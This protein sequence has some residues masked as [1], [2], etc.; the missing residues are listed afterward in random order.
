MRPVFSI[1][2]L[3]LIGHILFASVTVG[4][5]VSYAFWIALAELEPRHLAFTI[6]AVRHSDRLVAIPAYLLTFVT[7][8]WLV[9]ESGVPL[10]RLW[11]VVSLVVY[12][13][14]LVVG[15][16]VFGPTVR[17][18]LVAL[19]RGGV[20]DAEY[21]RLRGQAQLLSLGTIAALAMI[22]ALMVVKPY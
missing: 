16:A 14:V 11:I 13:A 9:Y 6:R 15:F 2:I 5:T 7:G 18:E 8:I 20:N 19:E 1:H 12:L 17:R 22:L 3:L 21:R 4:A 10:D